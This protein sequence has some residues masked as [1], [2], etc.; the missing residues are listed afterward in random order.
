LC[1]TIAIWVSLDA[2]L[3]PAFGADKTPAAQAVRYAGSASCR[4]CHEKFYQLWSASRHGLA[5]QP[6]TADF[7][8]KNLT[9]RVEEVRIGRL[10]TL[11]LAYDVKRK[12]WFDTAASG[13]RHV[14]GAESDQSVD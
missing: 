12:E 7:A 6:Y 13:I 11:P 9:S 10:Q 3:S 2:G 1:L 14:P 5:M 4:E 8:Q